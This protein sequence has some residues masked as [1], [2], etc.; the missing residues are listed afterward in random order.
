M[1]A[2]KHFWLGLFLITGV[3]ACIKINLTSHPEAPNIAEASK[4]SDIFHDIFDEDFIK[5]FKELPKSGEALKKPYTAHWYPYR[6]YGTARVFQ[7]KKQ[8]ALHKYSQ[9]FPS[10]DGSTAVDWERRFHSSKGSNW[11]GHCNGF[12]AASQRHF[13]P[14]FEVIRNGVRFSPADIKTLLTE[15]H[16]HVHTRILGGRRCRNVVIENAISS[17]GG[18]SC[19]AGFR[20]IVLGNGKIKCV[21]NPPA[22]SPSPQLSACEDVNAGTFHLALAN[23]VG[24]REQTIVFDKE[25]YNQVWNYPLFSYRLDDSSR[26]VSKAEALRLTRQRGPHYP[27]NSAATTFYRAKMHVGYADVLENT[28]SSGYPTFKESNDTYTYILE[29]DDFGDVVGGEWIDDSYHAHPDF[30][31]IA[32]EPQKS[33]TANQARQVLSGSA[34]QRYLNSMGGR[35]NPYL[36]P[37]TVN[38]MWAESVGLAPDATP[39]PL[40][41]ASGSALWGQDPRFSILLDGEANGSAF[42]GKEISFDLRLTDEQ[43]SHNVQVSLNNVILEPTAR[44]NAELHFTI[45][46]R[47]GINTLHLSFADEPAD[48]QVIFHAV[49]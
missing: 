22:R 44:S 32:L 25:A 2:L 46:P 41:L 35:S 30:L 1:L 48:K 27:F 36:D 28:E 20:K 3:Y 6:H 42:L 17:G 43:D 9:A 24:R 33:M 4:Q 13:E 15:V 16:L 18:T 47:P 5:K 34:L 45:L 11:T 23:W 37:A 38:E 19:P 21:K 26:Y 40:K 31:W 39:P 10:N 8:S 29:I 14:Q 7:G 49:Q 12:A